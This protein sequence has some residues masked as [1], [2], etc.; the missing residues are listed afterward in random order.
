MFVQLQICWELSTHFFRFSQLHITLCVQ[1]VNE[2]STSNFTIKLPMKTMIFTVS[3]LMD[4][5]CDLVCYCIC[6][7]SIHNE[8]VTLQHVQMLTYKQL[9]RHTGCGLHRK[10]L[11]YIVHHFE[12]KCLTNLWI[13]IDC[14][15]FHIAPMFCHIFTNV[16]K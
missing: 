1:F 10:S 3:L 8:T 16:A 15:F 4:N 11:H 6:R 7:S 2:C 5:S 9:L 14:Q 13:I 12:D